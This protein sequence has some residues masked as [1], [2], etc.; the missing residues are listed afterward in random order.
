MRIGSL[1]G[2]DAAKHFVGLAGTA[3]FAID[4]EQCFALLYFAFQPM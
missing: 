4:A 3:V 1:A 2:H